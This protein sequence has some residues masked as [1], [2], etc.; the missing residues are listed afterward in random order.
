MRACHHLTSLGPS[1]YQ[2][3]S[4]TLSKNFFFFWLNFCVSSLVAQMVN[5]LPAVRETGFDS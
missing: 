2:L 5:N 3:N 1:A 4:R